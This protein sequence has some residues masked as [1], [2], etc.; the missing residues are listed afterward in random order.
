MTD[1]SQKSIALIIPDFDLGGEEKRVVFFANNYL[2]YFKS[3]Y[4]FAPDGLSKKLLNPKVKHIVTNVRNYKKIFFVLKIINK[5]KIS[6]LQGHK[7]ATMPYLLA[8]EKFINTISIFNFDNIYPNYNNLCKFITPKHIVYLS[9]IVQNYYAN[10]YKKNIN[11]TI[12]MGGDFY[13]N[14]HIDTLQKIKIELGIKD[15]TILLSLGRLSYQKNHQKLIE[16][17]NKLKEENFICLIAGDGP[18]ENKIKMQIKK[19]QLS[20]KVRI[21]GHRTDVKNLLCISDVLIQAS[22]FE[23][24]PNVF[25]EAASVGLP[26]ISTDVGSSRTLVNKNGIVVH[27][28]DSQELAIAI[29]KMILNHSLYKKEA[30]VLRDSNFFKQFHKSEMLKNYISYYKSFLVLL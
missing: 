19:Y 1:L 11:K 2:E 21:L 22:I 27:A 29:R 17:L 16:S 28:N 9:D 5:E 7:R 14:S 12:N 8:S 18:L 4:L 30:M 15:E 3:V 10:Y 23:G 20:D 25:I 24:F 6:F 26:I 13:E